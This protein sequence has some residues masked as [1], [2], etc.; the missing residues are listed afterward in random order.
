MLIFVSVLDRRNIKAVSDVTQ[1]GDF[2]TG[3][4][5]QFGKPH[6]GAISAGQEAQIA[7]LRV[8]GKEA[9]H[10]N[11]AWA[12]PCGEGGAQLP[13]QPVAD[14]EVTGRPKSATK[15]MIEAAN[16]ESVGHLDERRATTAKHAVDF[17]ERAAYFVARNVLQDAV[18]KCL[19]ESFAGE[20]Q[21]ASVGDDV[22]GVNAELR[23][24]PAGGADTL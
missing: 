14:V 19:A 2:Q 22:V 10:S 4:A 3:A 5:E 17:C 13:R 24:H 20:G 18:R 16:P 1:R 23:G 9:V 21:V 8:E 15:L 11:A 7:E 6:Q 12:Y